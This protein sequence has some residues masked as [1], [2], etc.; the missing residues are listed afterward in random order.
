[1]GAGGAAAIALLCLAAPAGAAPILP[2][3]DLSCYLQWPDDS[4]IVPPAFWKEAPMGW[5]SNGGA[6]YYRSDN[7]GLPMCDRFIVNIALLAYSNADPPPRGPIMIDALPYDLPSSTDYERVTPSTEDDCNSYER[8]VTH[9][10]A[11]FGWQAAFELAGYREYYGS[12]HD[13]ACFIVKGPGNTDYPKMV[14]YD[15]ADATTLY[16]VTAT[17]KLRGS[18]QQVEVRAWPAFR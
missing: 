6:Y 8:K 7:T 14:L 1:M 4:Y 3:I 11:H 17:V 5:I 13:S 18:A 15:L 2:W 12:W 9:Y 16:R 10:V